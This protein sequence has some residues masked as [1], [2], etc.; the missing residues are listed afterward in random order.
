MAFQFGF[1]GEDVGAQEAADER[2]SGHTTVIP[3]QIDEC[4][5]PVRE[6]GIEELV[7]RTTRAVFFLHLKSA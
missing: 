1:D 5:V 7:G 2:P 6:H 4:K 3:V